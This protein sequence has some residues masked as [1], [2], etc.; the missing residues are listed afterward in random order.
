MNSI[1]NLYGLL[2][3]TLQLFLAGYLILLVLMEWLHQMGLPTDLYLMIVRAWYFPVIWLIDN[4]YC[5]W[6]LEELLKW[7]ATP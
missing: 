7:A 3:R 6:W 2:G 1:S 4:G 5:P